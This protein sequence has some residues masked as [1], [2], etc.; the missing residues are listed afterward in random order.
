VDPRVGL[1]AVAERE[2]PCPCQESNSCPARSLVT[3][4]TELPGLP[5]L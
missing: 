2:N 4:V 3:V 5:L 1:D